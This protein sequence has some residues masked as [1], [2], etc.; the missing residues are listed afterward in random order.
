M[1][2]GVGFVP[3]NNNVFPA[4]TIEENLQM[5][6]YLRPKLLRE[7]LDAMYELFPVLA[8]IGAASGPAG[9]PVVSGSRS[10]WRGRS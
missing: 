2:L 1:Q 10:R 9:S 3:Q 5:G 7:R 6:L 4:L 8:A